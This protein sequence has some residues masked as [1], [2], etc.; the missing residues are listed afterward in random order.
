VRLRCKTSLGWLADD[1]G[2]EA[3]ENAADGAFNTTVVNLIIF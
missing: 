1:A 2:L 3:S